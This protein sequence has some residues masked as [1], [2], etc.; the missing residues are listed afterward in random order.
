[1]DLVLVVPLPGDEDHELAPISLGL[2]IAIREPK[3]TRT[4][5]TA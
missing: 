5:G 3:A 2:R 1:V 4:I